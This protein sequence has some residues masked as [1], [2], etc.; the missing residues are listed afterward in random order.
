MG[1]AE[2]VRAVV[3]APAFDP[4][5]L[6]ELHPHA[7]PETWLLENP[8]WLSGGAYRWFRDELA[9]GPRTRVA[10]RAGAAGSGWVR[11]RRLG[12]ALAGAMAPEW[13]PRARAGW[14]GVTPAHGR[15]HLVRSL[16]EGNALALRDV[17]EAIAGAGY[18]PREVVCVGGGARARLNL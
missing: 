17:L 8:G 6:V 18:R 2:P 4:T 10:E 3:G 5:G 14:F 11:R 9:K 1:T 7:D 15:A 12:P 13:N 16:L